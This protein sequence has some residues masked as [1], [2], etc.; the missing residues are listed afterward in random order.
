[1]PHD[2]EDFAE[3]HLTVTAAAGH[4]VI[5]LGGELDVAHA[6]D[7]TR[8]LREQAAQGPVHLDLGE[9][10]FMDSTGVRL[11]DT[12]LREADASGWTVTL[13]PELHPAVRRVLEVTGMLPLLPFQAVASAA[14]TDERPGA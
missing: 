5:A 7:L 2:I 10:T 8:A 14:S 1:M 9:L 4:T 13:A 11:L 3:F 6:D 12:L